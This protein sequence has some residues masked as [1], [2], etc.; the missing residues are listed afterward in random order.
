MLN[1]NAVEFCPNINNLSINSCDS[2]DGD[3][4]NMSNEQGAHSIL[5]QLRLSNVNKVIIGHLNINSLRNKFEM[6]MDILNGVIDILV[7]SE[8]KLDDSFPFSQICIDG[9]KVF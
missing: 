4:S 6:I 5:H 7:V 1:A 3:P 8:T 2:L 9:Y